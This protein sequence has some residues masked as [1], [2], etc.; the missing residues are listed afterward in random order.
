MQEVQEG[1]LQQHFRLPDGLIHF[2]VDALGEKEESFSSAGG[3]RCYG[4]ISRKGSTG[5]M[6]AEGRSIPYDAGEMVDNL[7][8]ER[9][10]QDGY[11]GIAGKSL[12][13]DR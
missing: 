5:S 1:A 10:R 7:H 6:A 2:E 8:R 12:V 4:R 3:L 11:Q 13:R 9:Y